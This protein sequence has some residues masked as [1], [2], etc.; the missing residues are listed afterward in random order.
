MSEAVVNVE[1]YERNLWTQGTYPSVNLSATAASTNS[2]EAVWFYNSTLSQSRNGNNDGSY[3]TKWACDRT[4][5]CK[6]WGSSAERKMLKKDP[7]S[8]SIVAQTP[9]QLVDRGTHDALIKR[10]VQRMAENLRYGR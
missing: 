4:G 3:S 6:R 1:F 10:A 5:D 2:G 9:S 8:Y 7:D